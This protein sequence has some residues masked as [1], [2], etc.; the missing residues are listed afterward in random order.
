MFSLING[1][2]T[3]M[4]YDLKYI[5]I[6]IWLIWMDTSLFLIFEMPYE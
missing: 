6:V 3:E 4:S 5:W 2:M 1:L